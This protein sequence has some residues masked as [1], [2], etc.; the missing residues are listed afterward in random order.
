M[1]GFP[2]NG[3]LTECSTACIFPQNGSGPFSS[4]DIPGFP[5]GSQA[6]VGPLLASQAIS[7]PG[8]RIRLQGSAC[9]VLQSDE[10]FLPAG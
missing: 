3:S 10:I 6:C 1:E 5:Q 9:D 7:M 8:I 2:G 4:Q